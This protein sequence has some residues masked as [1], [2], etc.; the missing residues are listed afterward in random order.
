MTAKD[1]DRFYLN[2]ERTN[3]K[4]IQDTQ[5]NLL[6]GVPRP[7]GLFSRAY[8]RRLVK[9]AFIAGVVSERFNKTAPS[10]N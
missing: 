3:R 9:F 10:K 6:K 5:R 1:V 7:G 4:R 2:I 8:L